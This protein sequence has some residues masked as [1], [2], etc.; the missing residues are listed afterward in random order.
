MFQQG[1]FRDKMDSV[2]HL[3]NKKTKLQLRKAQ[4]SFTG[5]PLTS[6][7]ST[8]AK[9]FHNT[10]SIGTFIV[11]ITFLIIF[12]HILGARL[13]VQKF[14]SLINENLANVHAALRVDNLLIP[15]LEAK[16]KNNAFSPKARFLRTFFH[17]FSIRK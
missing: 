13:F 2:P 4:C 8:L 14:S 1:L 16:C 15:V 11:N 12:L 9:V 6:C 10:A 3:I 5:R 17:K 7:S